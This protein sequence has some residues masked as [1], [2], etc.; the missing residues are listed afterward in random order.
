MNIPED[1]VMLFSFINMKLRDEYNS[2]D[3]LCEDLGIDK[4]EILRKLKSIGFEYDPVRNR[5]W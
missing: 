3:D 2:L 5:F 1:P 4:Q